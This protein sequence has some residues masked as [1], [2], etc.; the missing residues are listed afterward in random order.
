MGANMITRVCALFLAV[1]GV[2]AIACN[3]P[4][5]DEAVAAT[6][7]D[8]TSEEQGSTAEETSTSTNTSSTTKTTVATSDADGGGTGSSSSGEGVA[9]DPV[10][11][12]KC[13]FPLPCDET[14]SYDFMC[15]RVTSY[16]DESGCPRQSCLTD[17]DCGSGM[18]CHDPYEECNR[19]LHGPALCL[20][21]E[22]EG[23]PECGCGVS[24][25]C[26]GPRLCVRSDLYPLGY[27]DPWPPRG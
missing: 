22:I 23:R 21:E 6:S 10:S 12:Y 13:S 16:I 9:C 15:D 27:C 3:A 2:G 17:D 11:W 8:A 25:A 5:V 24:G 14:A 1:G 18:R 20:E 4:V 26:G 19:C 7:G